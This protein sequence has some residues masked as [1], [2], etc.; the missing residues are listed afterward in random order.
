MKTAVPMR[1]RIGPPVSSAKTRVQLTIETADNGLKMSWTRPS[2]GCGS[3]RRKIGLD[4]AEFKELG[5]IGKLT[6]GHR[7]RMI[8]QL[9]AQSARVSGGTG[10]SANSFDTRGHDALSCRLWGPR[11]RPARRVD[12]RRCA[13]GDRN[14]RGEADRRAD[15]ERPARHRCPARQT[16][17]RRAVPAV[18]RAAPDVARPCRLGSRDLPVG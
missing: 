8:G 17:G 5:P 13:L 11:S 9:K 7:Q 3:F 16:P 14:P 18:G 4:G 15:R 2:S 6:G 10:G 12:H 1:R